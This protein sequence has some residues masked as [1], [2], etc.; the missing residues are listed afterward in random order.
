M[1]LKP[2]GRVRGAAGHTGCVE[3][4]PDRPVMSDADNASEARLQGLVNDV[5]D[6]LFYR[7]T[8]VSHSR[9]DIVSN[10]VA[11]KMLANS[12]AGNGAGLVI[13]VCA[14]TDDR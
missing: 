11:D 10:R 14:G 9:G 4:H 6:R 8:F 13:G 1:D 7:L 2:T 3:V 5:A 12:G